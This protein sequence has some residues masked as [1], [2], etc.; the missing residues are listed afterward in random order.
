MRAHRRPG[1]GKTTLWE[2]GIAL[3]RAQGL[4]VLSARASGADARLSFAAL[5]D[6]L[7]GVETEELAGLPAPQPP[8]WRWRF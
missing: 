6:L 7:D 5:I 2:G 3:A 8:R 4:R 1:I